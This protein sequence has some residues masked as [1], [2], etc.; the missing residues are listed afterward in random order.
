MSGEGANSRRLLEA[1]LG[2]HRLGRLDE[3]ASLYR[4]LLSNQPR[5]AQALQL[6]GTL[7]Q[8]RGRSAAALRLMRQAVALEPSIAWYHGNVAEAQRAAGH[9][10]AA[11]ASARRGHAIL[12]A[13]EETLLVLGNV[14]AEDGDVLG[15][16][17]AF[18]RALALAP[19]YGEAANNLGDLWSQLQQPDMARRSFWRVL[20]LQPLHAAARTN[21][22]NALYGMGEAPAALHHYRLAIALEPDAAETHVGSGVA[23]RQCAGFER[24]LICYRRALVLAPGSVEARYNMSLVQLTRGDYAGGWPGFALRRRIRAFRPIRPEPQEPLWQGE[25]LKGRSILLHAEQGHGDAIQFARYVPM[26]AARGGRVVLEC[27]PALLR[28]FASLAG[29]AHLRARGTELP[30]FDLHC[31]LMSL[32]EVFD[33]GVDSIPATTPYLAVS[34]E[35]T[36]RWQERLQRL[37]RPR[38]GLCWR[39]S[40]TFREDRTRSPGLAAFEPILALEGPSF[41][42][43]MPDPEPDPRVFDVTALLDDFAETAAAIAVLDL[44]ITSDTAVAH[45][46]GALGRPAWVMLQHVPDWRW[47]LERSDS[48]WYP[49]LRLYRQPGPGDWLSVA[50]QIAAD[51]AGYS[52]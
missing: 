17:V 51:L 9:R 5:H 46:A 12:A 11:V 28:L 2:Q 18:Q 15:A 29:A 47:F 45:L 1:A 39:G 27:H 23:W 7:E 20:A 3:A 19:A 30:Q 41:A 40:R 16:A 43:L 33:T 4:Q 50:L 25:D 49:S 52:V 37:P 13:A 42:A 34:D 36:A 26:V 24:A 21:L 38:I 8:Q 44:V 6:L 10:K 22:A 14:L 35:A 48:P 32:A 31:P